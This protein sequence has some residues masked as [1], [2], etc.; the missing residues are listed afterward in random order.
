MALPRNE[1][2]GVDALAN[3]EGDAAAL[4]AAE[5]KFAAFLVASPAY[6][7]K[8][9]LNAQLLKVIPN[10]NVHP[11][12][13]IHNELTFDEAQAKLKEL[14][15]QL[16]FQYALSARD[17]GH[18]FICTQDYR[19]ISELLAVITASLPI[20]I[21]YFAMSKPD[22]VT[23]ALIL[24]Q[25]PSLF[26]N[27]VFS[28]NK[29]LLTLLTNWFH[30][31]F[32]ADAFKEFNLLNL[33]ATLPVTEAS[34][35][36]MLAAERISFNHA[37]KRELAR[38]SWTFFRTTMH[39]DM[40]AAFLGMLD[41]ENIQLIMGL[42]TLT[43]LI[44]EATPTQIAILLKQLA[45][46]HIPFAFD[47]AV[48]KPV[49]YY[50]LYEPSW[51]HTPLIQYVLANTDASFHNA[52]LLQH[53]K[54]PPLLTKLREAL[55]N[56]PMPVYEQAKNAWDELQAEK[57]IAP[58]PAAIPR[59][60]PFEGVR[61]DA[62]ILTSKGEPVLL[63]DP[64]LIS[65]IWQDGL[66]LP[67]DYRNLDH[68]ETDKYRL[69]DLLNF[70]K[71]RKTL[72]TGFGL[73]HS[74]YQRAWPA[75]DT[76]HIEN[77]FA[78]L[79]EASVF[80]LFYAVSMPL[81]RNAIIAQTFALGSMAKHFSEANFVIVNR[82]FIDHYFRYQGYNGFLIANTCN[83]LREILIRVFSGDL[84]LSLIEKMTHDFNY[85]ICHAGKGRETAL[86]TIVKSHSA[87][88]LSAV[89]NKLSP[90]ALAELCVSQNDER[91]TPLHIAATSQSSA[92]F[93]HL[94]NVMDAG[95]L[96]DLCRI[97]SNDG[98]SLL[99][100]AFL[101]Q[102]PESIAKLL[103][104]I[105]VDALNYML[106]RHPMQETT[107]LK[108]LNSL[109]H[110][111]S[112][113]EKAFV[114]GIYRLLSDFLSSYLVAYWLGGH[115]IPEHLFACLC[116]NLFDPSLDAPAFKRMVLQDFHNP[117][118]KFQQAKH[119]AKKDGD[120]R[121]IVTGQ[122]N[123]LDL[124]HPNLVLTVWRE[125]F[126]DMGE[127]FYAR[128]QQQN[129]PGLTSALDRL[130][131]LNRIT[132]GCFQA[133]PVES[134]S[135]I[136]LHQVSECIGRGNGLVQWIQ[137]EDWEENLLSLG[138]Y[139]YRPESRLM[140]DEEKG[141]AMRFDHLSGEIVACDSIPDSMMHT[142]SLPVKLIGDNFNINILS[143]KQYNPSGVGLMYRLDQC[144]IT[145]MM[146]DEVISDIR[147]SMGPKAYVEQY[148]A[149]VKSVSH[150]DLDHFRELI[151][152][153]HY[154]THQAFAR[155]SREAVMAVVITNPSISAK[156]IALDYADDFKKRFGIV[157]PVVAYS[158]F[159]KML[160]LY[161][162]ESRV[163]D[164]LRA[165]P[166]ESLS[167][168]ESK[169]RVLTF[170][171]EVKGKKDWVTRGGFLGMKRDPGMAS[172]SASEVVNFMEKAAVNPHTLW[173]STYDATA[174][175]LKDAIKDSSRTKEVETQQF[176]ESSMRKFFN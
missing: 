42:T 50:L 5:T 77:L 133:L 171:A 145:A 23:Q 142:R 88:V 7:Y 105:D 155:L 39:E 76:V 52:L 24:K 14:S 99:E 16:G 156:K 18:I 28:G 10:A 75:K 8:N 144:V 117:W 71:E 129:I 174:R 175:F 127:Y 45:L 13:D 1:N 98:K 69:V 66:L 46:L 15:N 21:S 109:L 89:L 97:F 82:D 59:C 33:L 114:Q 110:E 161:L 6:Q 125:G 170:L 48:E 78:E 34:I 87:K 26:M 3:P 79:G 121:K 118:R 106:T 43:A 122:N 140:A 147:E 104:K 93:D 138:D 27:T 47:S 94:V 72:F 73:D 152:Q 163:S 116:E 95:S 9:A 103:T 115:T 30:P 173:S 25:H 64:Q 136:D 143:E 70:L 38:F 151:K 111:S 36:F 37:I 113:Q 158:S 128:R 19:P 131:S 83:F 108:I 41:A 123:K 107:L 169:A 86:H 20:K 40:F 167:E 176:Y 100:L 29:P 68:V 124:N 96:S 84:T 81:I 74:L 130:F 166:K 157:L 139:H 172:V 112:W 160:N 2:L 148:A 164:G 65:R 132:T 168:L 135:A 58:V 49:I 32:I 67:E 102:N 90:E 149:K 159:I 137:P 31:V 35:R 22:I 150:S 61:T 126:R 92:G 91:Q 62:N 101:K 85:I 60:I 55:K 153:N 53:A 57:N 4:Q 11:L 51:Q 80:R 134:D 44:T 162:P 56:L 17:A 54:L 154:R 63:T 12:N 146:T 141:S 120:V 165:E 119:P